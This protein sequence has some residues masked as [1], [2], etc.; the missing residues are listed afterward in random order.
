MGNEGLPIALP[1]LRSFL[2][3]STFKRLLEAHLLWREILA[4][5]DIAKRPTADRHTVQ[6]LRGQATPSS[7]RH[8]SGRVV[9]RAGMTT[10]T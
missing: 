4:K 5:S 1:L 9:L 2:P 3:Y 6:T 7:V 8:A 10:E